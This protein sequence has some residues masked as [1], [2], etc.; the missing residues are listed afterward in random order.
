MTYDNMS[1]ND[2]IFLVQNTAWWLLF[3]PAEKSHQ[4]TW[5]S[6]PLMLLQ[7]SIGIPRWF[8]QTKILAASGAVV[9][10][11]SMVPTHWDIG[12]TA[13]LLLMNMSV[14]MTFWGRHNIRK[15]RGFRQDCAVTYHKWTH[16]EIYLIVNFQLLAQ[17]TWLSQFTSETNFW[18]YLMTSCSWPHHK[19]W[20]MWL[21]LVN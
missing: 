10:H 5:R 13:C 4:R 14:G 3:L 6:Q 20:L 15:A 18:D 1:H 11:S 9:Y 16:Y 8:I 21:F 17:C 12:Q 7:L 2:D 19:Q